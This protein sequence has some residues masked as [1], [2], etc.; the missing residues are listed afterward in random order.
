MINKMIENGTKKNWTPNELKQ[1]QQELLQQQKEGKDV[2]ASLNTQLTK[3]DEW[4][5]VREKQIQQHREAQDA[6]NV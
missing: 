4:K 3:L 5:G 6:Q 1:I 2:H